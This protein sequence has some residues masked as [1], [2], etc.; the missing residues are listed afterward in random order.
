[1]SRKSYRQIFLDEGYIYI[2]KLLSGKPL[3]ELY[4]ACN[5]VL[6]KYTEHH[7]V[8]K[9]GQDFTHMRNLNN[10]EW[11]K[12]APEAF[13]T[14]MELVADPRCLGPI[15]QI[16]EGPSL[17]R[18]LT[19]WANP[20]YKSQDG[21]WHRDTQFVTNSEEEEQEYLKKFLDMDVIRGAH[22]Q[23]ALVDNS[24]LEYVPFSAG[25]F[26]TP[27]EHRI[28]LA[29]NQAHSREAGMPNAA[30]LYMNAGDA[31][32]L[33]Q[34]G[35]HRGRYHTDKFRRTLMLSYTPLHNPIFDQFIYDQT[36]FLHE[37]YLNSLSPRAVVYF[38]EFIRVFKEYLIEQSTPTA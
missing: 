13:K 31:V 33:N 24:D 8:G 26:D 28:R 9:P 35:I 17:F 5:Y 34:N 27:E 38:Q 19:Y 37:G 29:D 7:D 30:R 20:R 11:T 12:N 36:W 14:I 25:R 1:M 21:Q 10:P 22:I 23:I 2:P 6:D 15:E 16:F 3:E 32:I 18:V 4:H